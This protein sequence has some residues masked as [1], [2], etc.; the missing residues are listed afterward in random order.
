MPVL[1]ISQKISSARTAESAILTEK[2]IA[3]DDRAFNRKFLNAEV[4]SRDV[5]PG[6]RTSLWCASARS[7]IAMVCLA[8]G[9][10]GKDRKQL[11]RDTKRHDQKCEEKWKR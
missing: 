8:V 5:A 3:D 4:R 9:M 1:V 10:A 2:I 6:R 11:M 7:N